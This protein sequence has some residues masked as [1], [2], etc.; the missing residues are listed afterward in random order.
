[1]HDMNIAGVVLSPKRATRT[2]L[3]VSPAASDAA[4]KGPVMRGSRPTCDGECV[5]G[6]TLCPM[7][8]G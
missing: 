7:T 6:H 2:P 3:L 8:R 1:M 5:P 4:S